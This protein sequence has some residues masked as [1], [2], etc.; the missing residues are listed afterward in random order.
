MY[1]SKQI[2]NLKLTSKIKSILFCPNG[3]Y[4]VIGL[5]NGTIIVYLIQVDSNIH[6]IPT[7]R[8]KNET[9]VTSTFNLQVIDDYG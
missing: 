1:K 3:D 8:T 9:E 7:K 5:S 2:A 6:K 4:L